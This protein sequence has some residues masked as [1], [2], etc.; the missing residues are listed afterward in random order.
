MSPLLA[1]PVAVIILL[2]AA[3]RLATPNLVSD[4]GPGKRA[5]EYVNSLYFTNW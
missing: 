1:G 5:N 4:N 2:Q 3:F